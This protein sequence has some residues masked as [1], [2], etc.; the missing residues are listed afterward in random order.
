MATA[1]IEKSKQDLVRELLATPEGK[2]M[3]S[4]EIAKQVGGNAANISRIVKQL[5]EAP[6]EPR[7]VNIYDLDLNRGTQQRPELNVDREIELSQAFEAGQYVDPIEVWVTPEAGMVPVDG[8][9]RIAGALRAGREDILAILKEGSLKDAIIESCAANS[10][11]VL[12]RCDQTKRNAVTTLLR[13]WEES[14]AALPE[15]ER[16]RPATNWLREQA[17][18]HD[19]TVNRAVRDF[20]ADRDAPTKVTTKRGEVVNA[21]APKAAKPASKPAPERDED[22]TPSA[23]RVAEPV[24]AGNYPDTFDDP[25]PEPA[26]KTKPRGAAKA[27][28]DREWLNDLKRPGKI[29][30]RARLQGENLRTFNLH[31]LAY[32]ADHEDADYLAWAQKARTRIGDRKTGGLSGGYAQKVSS[33]LRILHP[34]D[35]TLCHEC[36]G[37]GVKDGQKCDS[38]GCG[39][40]GFKVS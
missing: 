8:F 21:P 6:P 14:Q 28:A 32:K 5:R 36:H 15:A 10:R 13:I 20:Y 1:T 3:T 29:E 38:A 24:K 26:A 35:W 33:F 11:G 18:V 31:A 16:T 23:R 40:N 34:A 22:D 30:V 27:E 19:S 25:E 39:G 9:H 17:R 37:A 12:P 2:T 7:L 4:A